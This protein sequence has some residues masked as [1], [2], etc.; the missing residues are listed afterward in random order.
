MAK[1]K[2]I[3]PLK[4]VM[5]IK[6]IVKIVGANQTFSRKPNSFTMSTNIS[7]K[8]AGRLSLDARSNRAIAIGEF[9]SKDDVCTKTSL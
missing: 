1:S 4:D 6:L 7:L 8:T 2:D 9:G 5:Y 3:G